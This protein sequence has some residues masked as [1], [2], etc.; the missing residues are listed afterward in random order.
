M[1]GLSRIGIAGGVSGF[2]VSLVSRPLLQ[3]ITPIAAAAL[4]ALTLSHF[5]GQVR[6]R[7]GSIGGVAIVGVTLLMEPLENVARGI[8]RG[9]F[10]LFATFLLTL[11]GYQITVELHSRI[12]SS[13]LDDDDA[14]GE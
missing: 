4:V 11:V 6:R 14:T 3:V 9:I 12:R 10:S 13:S 5:D 8:T 2:M 7:Y 1:F